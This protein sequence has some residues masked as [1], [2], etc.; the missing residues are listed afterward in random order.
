M[1]GPVF[2]N[3]E[4]ARQQKTLAGEFPLEQLERIAS[5]VIGGDAVEYGLAGGRDHRLRYTLDLRLVGWLEL[6]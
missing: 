3:A 2:D 5:E 4:F 6:K 1:S